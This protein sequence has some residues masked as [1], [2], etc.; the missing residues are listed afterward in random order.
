[1][2][3]RLGKLSI[4]LALGVWLALGLC[5]CGGA[6][7]GSSNSGSTT[8]ASAEASGESGTAPGASEVV[9]KFGSTPITRAEVNH[10][11]PVLAAQDYYELSDAHTEPEGLVSDPPRY[12]ACVAHLEAA[13]AAASSAQ[14]SAPPAGVELLS[15]CRL[16]N[17]RIRDQ[18]LSFLI[19]L[20]I[21]EAVAEEQ[22]VSAS[23][24]EVLKEY[25]ASTHKQFA[26][27]AQRDSSALARRTTRA[28]ELVLSR[29][30]LLSRK[31]LERIKAS[32]HGLSQIAALEKALIAKTD[33]SPGYVVAECSQFH[34]EAPQSPANPSA[35]ILSE[36]LAALLT[37]RCTNK[38]ACGKQ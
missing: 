1:M 6:S 13:L 26:S 25:E 8:N 15:K 12:G 38:A 30:D 16:L 4:A 37:G 18:A 33:C 3:G 22:G 24:A 32:G 19:N 36:Q 11:M 23:E 7:G 9:V 14:K 29:R 17:Q 35:A 21:V 27:K 2:H 10:W 34:G 5:A 20:K 31:A 28:N